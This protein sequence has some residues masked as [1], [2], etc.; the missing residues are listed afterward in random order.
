MKKS[1]R[2]KDITQIK[3]LNKDRKNNP[4]SGLVNN[5][6]EPLIIEKKKKYTFCSHLAPDLQFDIK[7]S[8][9]EK[10]IDKGL[11]NC[12]EAK[13]ALKKLKNMQ[14]P[15]LNWAGKSEK[16][17]FEVPTVSLHTHEKIDS[18]AII[19]QVRKTNSVNYEQ[20]SI[21]QN[22]QN[23]PKKRAINFYQ[24]D[25]KWS[26]RLIAGD[27]LLVMNSLLEKEGMG[28]KVQC[29]YIDPPYGIKYGSNFQPFTNKKNVTD[30][31]DEDLTSEP[32]MLKAFR[33]TWE[34]KIHSYLSYLRDRLLL[35]RDLLT[36][37]G[38]CF[39][40]ISDEN[41]HLVRNLMD[42]VFEREN[43][44]TQI[45]FRT[46]NMP[47]NPK[48]LEQMCDFALWYSKDKSKVKYRKL[49]INKNIQGNSLWKYIGFP[50]GNF[51]KLTK[52]EI[53]NHSLLEKDFQKGGKFF[54]S[55]SIEP[56]GKNEKR[57]FAVHFEGKYYKPSNSW[58]YDKQT[59][60]KLIQKKLLIAEGNLLRGKYFLDFYPV[61][62]L[63][64]PWTDTNLGNIK[65]YVVQT[66][67]KTIER[68]VLMT[69]DPG[70][71]V[72]DPTCGSGTTAYVAE[73]WGRRWITC[74]T[75][76]VA[77]TLAKQRLM[78][79]VFDYYNLKNKDEGISS[80]FE[81]KTV[82]HITLGSIANNEPPEQ[83][84]LYDTPLQDNKK[85][86]VTGPFTV[87]AVPSHVVQTLGQNKKPSFKYDWLDQVKKTGIRGKKGVTTDM[88]FARLE[89]L[90]GFK[91]LHAEG[92]TK[93]PRGVV[94]SFGP[95]HSPLDK[96]HVELALKEM[97]S[98]KEKPD[99]LVFAAFHFDPEA[100]K[101]INECKLE[102]TKVVQIQMNMDLQ[103][104][105]LKK[106]TAK[107]SF[108]LIGSPDV[109]VKN[110]SG[111]NKDA[112][113]V[114]VRGWDYYN[115]ASGK[116][117]SGGQNKI[118]MWVLDTDYN[119]RAVFPRQV[120]F[121]M[122]GKSDG[123]AKLA[124]SLKSEIDKDLIEKYKGTKSLPFKAGKNKK[125]AVKIIDDRGI[126]SL[127]V[128]DFPK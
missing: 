89:K 76:R 28:G 52:K 74:D 41:V 50:N 15:Y 27:S 11:S 97:N 117:E 120:F 127:R 29:V 92:E 122:A 42:E 87:E 60:K 66:A 75:S 93:N 4:P 101:L 40:Q 49:Y 103:T 51:R 35:A 24:H 83:E 107:D 94:I 56:V 119:G 104:S 36:E 63:T 12:K 81:Y 73:K 53:N 65:T 86:R 99:I 8:E 69:T 77:V 13:L 126:E 102:K 31:K 67:V 123:W 25:R 68:C 22:E 16:T 124:K 128:F 9:I 48:Y 44:I 110:S 85:A 17:S 111:A 71:L 46:K 38:S 1:K 32:E 14:Q 84:V 59:I 95:E 70:D 114:E 18:R 82:P 115:P 91:Y 33:D 78:T 37:S 57:T 112:Y 55:V 20:L 6:T 26:N 7:R 125:I 105:D 79:A 100:S 61:Q 62:A 34:F 39:V 58:K 109:E 64:T 10:I 106:K 5:K 98:K 113:V 43:F 23:I 80:G 21:F 30:K 108:W 90:S 72:F 47:M 45:A 118:A 2:K 116:I 96:R 54:Q 3:H 19:E 121:P 88:H